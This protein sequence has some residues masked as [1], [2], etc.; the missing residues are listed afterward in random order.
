[1]TLAATPKVAVIG[2]PVAAGLDDQFA[3]LGIRVGEHQA[4]LAIIEPPLSAPDGDRATVVGQAG[5]YERR[6]GDVAE[7]NDRFDRARTCG[8]ASEAPGGLRG[9]RQDGEKNGQGKA[10]HVA[11]LPQA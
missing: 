8:A 9:G 11:M 7:A 10:V 1:M 3:P 6:A 4:E 2:A 5:Q